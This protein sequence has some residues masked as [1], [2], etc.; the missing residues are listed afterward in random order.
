MNGRRGFTIIELLIVAVLML[1]LVA[2]IGHV[3][4]SATIATQVHSAFGKLRSGQDEAMNRMTREIRQSGDGCTD[5][6]VAAGSLTFNIC[7]GFDGITRTWGPA[8]TYALDAGGSLVRTENGNAAIILKRVTTL[9]FTLNGSLL[10]ILLTSEEPGVD[11]EAMEATCT[12]EV[13]LNNS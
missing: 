12:G 10:E 2:V 11:Q 13:F 3:M 4:R 1:F 5:W 6:S 7:N 9:T 8:I